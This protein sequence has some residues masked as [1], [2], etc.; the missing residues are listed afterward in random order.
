MA[1]AEGGWASAVNTTVINN[2]GYFHFSCRWARER[3]STIIKRPRAS[4]TRNE[5]PRRRVE[6]GINAK[7][8]AVS[9]P[10]FPPDLCPTVKPAM[11]AKM[12]TM[13]GITKKIL[14]REE[15][16][17]HAKLARKT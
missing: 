9:S 3:A 13:L 5:G 14:R 4:G 17:I 7:K 6:V 11:P 1:I 8:N 2:T 12:A 15:P 10:H 16:D